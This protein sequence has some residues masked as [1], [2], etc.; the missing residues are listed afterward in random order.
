MTRVPHELLP[1]RSVCEN[2]VIVVV[3]PAFGSNPA[4]GHGRQERQ[5]Q[6]FAERMNRKIDPFCVN[7]RWS[8]SVVLL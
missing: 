1:N 3:F 6:R 5:R 2:E 4:V 8:S 7:R